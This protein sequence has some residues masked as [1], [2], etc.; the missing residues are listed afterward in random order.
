M[1]DIRFPECPEVV[2]LA[3]TLSITRIAK[4]STIIADSV[5]F[6]LVDTLYLAGKIVDVSHDRG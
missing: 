4:N 5:S 3:R 1:H 6:I 2:V